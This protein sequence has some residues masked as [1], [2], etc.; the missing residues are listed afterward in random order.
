MLDLFL[1]CYRKLVFTIIQLK[2]YEFAKGSL[3]ALPAGCPSSALVT[4]PPL[5]L[6][7]FF[8]IST[9]I[10]FPGKPRG[11]EMP[12]VPPI[13]AEIFSRRPRDII[14]GVQ[15]F[16]FCHAGKKEIP[17]SRHLQKQRYNAQLVVLARRVKWWR[18][19]A[20]IVRAMQTL[21]GS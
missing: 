5:L 13:T 18:M 16:L 6:G 1:T 7:R 15:F 9:P 17:V 12:E 10:L 19:P 3:L 8:A 11:C 21:C 4:Y 20:V 14:H 2:R